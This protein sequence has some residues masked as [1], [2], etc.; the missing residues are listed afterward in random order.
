MTLKYFVVRKKLYTAS[1]VCLHGRNYLSCNL[2]FTV[3]L[4]CFTDPDPE[5]PEPTTMSECPSPDT[6][7]SPSKMSKVMSMAFK[8]DF[9]PA[10][11][12]ISL[13]LLY[14]SC[15]SFLCSAMTNSSG[16]TLQYSSF[17]GKQFYDLPVSTPQTKA[18]VIVKRK[19]EPM[20]IYCCKLKVRDLS[21]LDF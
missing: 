5:N 12:S 3:G 2:L 10:I 6:S 18:Q 16:S 13:C 14:P 15:L 7:Q 20:F 17:H 4:F 21:A 8:S 19:A 1:T 11:S 9:F